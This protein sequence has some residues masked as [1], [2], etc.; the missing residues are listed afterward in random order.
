MNNNLIDLASLSLEFGKVN[1][2]TMHK[3]GVTF[4]SDTDH[5]FMLSMLACSMAQKLYKDLNI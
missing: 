2:K 5:T 4:E 1:R 3:D